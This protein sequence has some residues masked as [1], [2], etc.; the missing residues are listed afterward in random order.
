MSTTA[1]WSPVVLVCTGTILVS[2][3][4]VGRSP[5]P[6]SLPESLTPVFSPTDSV[7]EPGSKWRPLLCRLQQR[8]IRFPGA[9][10]HPT[11]IWV[12]VAA[13]VHATQLRS[14]PSCRLTDKRNGMATRQ[15]RGGAV[16]ETPS[17]GGPTPKI[18]PACATYSPPSA[19]TPQPQKACRRG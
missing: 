18:V 6:F 11:S 15:L 19:E 5:L 16:R 13:G 1:R 4:L 7:G 12:R 14:M 3:N 17:A 2:D 10:F 8:V 9:G